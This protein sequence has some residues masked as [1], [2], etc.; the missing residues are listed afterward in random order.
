[1]SRPAARKDAVFVPL[2]FMRVGL[3]RSP[4]IITQS[5]PPVESGWITA[6][7]TLPA[8]ASVTTSNTVSWAGE[9]VMP[10]DQKRSATTASIR[11]TQN[12]STLG[13]KRSGGMFFSCRLGFLVSLSGM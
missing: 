2:S 8:S 1:M 11:A 13:W 9:T 6:A 4:L 12:M 3:F 7:F 10:G 5:R